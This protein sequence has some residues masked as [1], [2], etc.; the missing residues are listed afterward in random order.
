MMNQKGCG[1]KF[2]WYNLRFCL[3]NLL[4]GSEE[5]QQKPVK[6]CVFILLF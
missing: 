1:R 5:N 6:V 3:Q 2:S 4:R